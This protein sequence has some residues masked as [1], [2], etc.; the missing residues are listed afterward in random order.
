MQHAPAHTLPH[1][2]PFLQQPSAVTVHVAVRIP[3][4]LLGLLPCRQAGVYDTYAT[5]QAVLLLP[6]SLQACWDFYHAARH[7]F[8]ALAEATGSLQQRPPSEHVQSKALLD[9]AALPGPAKLGGWV[10]WDSV[11]QQPTSLK[12]PQLKDAARQLGVMVRFVCCCCVAALY[13]SWCC[14]E[15]QCVMP[16][17]T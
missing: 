3:A 4:G 8:Q 11:V 12:L 13:V 6:T 17:S 16:C 5:E 14:C 15:V 7:G 9:L 10:F 2:S 1:L